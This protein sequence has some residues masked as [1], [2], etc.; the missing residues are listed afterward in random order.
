MQ[1]TKQIVPFFNEYFGV[2]YAL[3][4][5]DQVAVPGGIF[6]AMENWGAIYYNEARLLY[7]ESEPSLRQQQ[8]VYG[9]IAHEVAHQWFGNLVTMAWWDNLW[10]NEGFAT[11]MATKTARRFYPDWKVRLRSALWRQEAMTDDARR[12]TLPIQTP[13]TDDARAMDVFDS[14]TYSK[15]EAFIGML[16][17][18]L[19][20]EVFRDGI[21]RYMRAH[22]YSNTTTADLWHHLSEASGREVA[23]LAGP[24]TEQPGFP[25]VKVVQRCANGQAVA[26]LVQERFTLND[27]RAARL[28]WKVPVTLADASGERQTVLLER[29]PPRLRLPRRGLI[30]VHGRDGYY[31]A[32][33]DNL[34][35]S[36][37]ARA[38]GRLEASDTPRALADPF[39]LM[40]AGGLDA[41]QYL[42]LVD[43]LG[44]EDDPR[45]WEHVIEALR[46]LRELIDAPADQA[47]LDRAMAR[48]PGRAFARV[49]WS[50]Q[51]DRGADRALLR[52]LLVDALGR[53]GDAATVREAQARFAARESKPI[54]ATLRQALPNVVVRYADD[55]TFEALMRRARSA[56]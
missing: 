47:A 51:P 31:P 44:D 21:R 13:V 11:W 4:K 12:T 37:L 3:P 33:Y 32:Q 7:D 46:F 24:W 30:P 10:L 1:A 39:A 40:Q 26:T 48:G 9:I 29:A 54:D 41:G 16:E 6:G 23:A 34:S 45:I 53:A 52:R 14:I 19:G 18:Y 36:Y 25:V 17:S 55:A 15:G 35:L 38:L 27:P 8:Q 49:G 20:E 2:R 42:A 5:L 28:T 56:L 43:A 22:Q 50:T